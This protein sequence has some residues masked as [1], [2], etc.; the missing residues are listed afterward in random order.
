MSKKFFDISSYTEEAHSNQA[1]NNDNNVAIFALGLSGETG[2]VADIVKKLLRNPSM[3]DEEYDGKI[4]HL[5]EELGDVLWY[6]T[7][8]LRYFNFDIDEVAN[9]NLDKLRARRKDNQLLER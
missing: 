4:A 9:L 3:T 7:Q 5:K 8:L 1:F 6:Y 2:E